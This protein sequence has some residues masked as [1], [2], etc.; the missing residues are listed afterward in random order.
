MMRENILNNVYKCSWAHCDTT[1]AYP[2]LYS[3][4]SKNAIA[5]QLK[6]KTKPKK[7]HSTLPSFMSRASG[8]AQTFEFEWDGSQYK[9]VLKDANNVLGNF[10]FSS[11][12]A[13]VNFS[14]DG[15]QLI[16]NTELLN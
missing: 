7:D 11:S 1:Q 9:A 5:R 15:N 14:V 2:N 12:E 10:T 4:N 8:S 6:K 16:I 3:I 13:G